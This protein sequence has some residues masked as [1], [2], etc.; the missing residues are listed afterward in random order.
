MEIKDTNASI[1]TSQDPFSGRPD[2]A[3]NSKNAFLPVSMAVTP[4]ADAGSLLCPVVTLG[5]FS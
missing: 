4:G 1:Q 2:Q 5:M 3:T